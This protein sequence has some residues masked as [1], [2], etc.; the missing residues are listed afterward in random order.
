ME[1]WTGIMNWPIIEGWKCQTC[2]EET[3]LI[4]GMI[5]GEC[6]CSICHTEYFMK[7]KDG[8]RIDNPRCTLKE[9]YVMPTQKAWEKL[10]IPM[11][12]MTNEEWEEFIKE[13]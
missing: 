7:N 10:G 1:Y 8:T 6:R 3:Y 12:E 13:D 2:K 5:N 9:K 4:W 11:D